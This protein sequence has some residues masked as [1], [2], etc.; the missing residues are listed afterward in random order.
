[1]FAKD[2]FDDFGEGFNAYKNI[3]G[4]LELFN[5]VKVSGVYKRIPK[6]TRAGVSSAVI[7]TGVNNTSSDIPVT[8]KSLNML[9]KFESCPLYSFIEV[10]GHLEFPMY[11]SSTGKNVRNK[12]EFVADEM[13]IKKES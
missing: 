12:L 3:E 11:I 1:M 8:I 9:Q 10:K 13:Q 4:G 7:T 2:D 5:D 6:E